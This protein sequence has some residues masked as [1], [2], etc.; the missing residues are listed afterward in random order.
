MIA[1]PAARTRTHPHGTAPPVYHSESAGYTHI[2]H[3]GGHPFTDRTN[4]PNCPRCGGADIP[5]CLC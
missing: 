4:L 2:A 5:V 3:W 1:I